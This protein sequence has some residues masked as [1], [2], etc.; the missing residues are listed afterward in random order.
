MRLKLEVREHNP[1]PPWKRAADRPPDRA[2]IAS[3]GRSAVVLAA[4]GPAADY[5]DNVDHP[6]TWF[7]EHGFDAGLWVVEFKLHSRSYDTDVGREYDEELEIVSD[8]RA[9]AEEAQAAA[10]GGHPW[11]PSLW[12]EVENPTSS[13]ENERQ[14]MD[15]EPSKAA[16][17]VAEGIRK[18]PLYAGRGVPRE[19]TVDFLEAVV[20]L[21]GE[22][23]QTLREEMDREGE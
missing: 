13:S 23:I 2:L 21:L 15:E 10:E 4:I 22:D 7:C 3:S 5:M 19:V 17:K 14:E 16:A 8:R 18:H 9:T 6:D 1:T 12:M 20:E 11:D